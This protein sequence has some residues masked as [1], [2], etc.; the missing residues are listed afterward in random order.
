M[1]EFKEGDEVHM[2]DIVFRRCKVINSFCGMDLLPLDLEEDNLQYRVIADKE[3]AI[4][5]MIKRLEELKD[6]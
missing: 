1:S 5:A 4:D 2:V 6:E 3:K